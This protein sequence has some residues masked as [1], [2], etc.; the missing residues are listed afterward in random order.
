MSESRSGAGIQPA[1]HAMQDSDLADAAILMDHG[2]K[3][4]TANPSRCA[5]AG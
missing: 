4:A 5:S 1:I 2:I 3:D